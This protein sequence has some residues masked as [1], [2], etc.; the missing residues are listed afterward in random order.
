MILSQLKN[1]TMASNIL[2]TFLI[3]ATLTQLSAQSSFIED[4]KLKWKNVTE[5]TLEFAH[6]MPEDYY[7]YTPTKV[8]M[9]YREQLKHVAGNMLWLCSSFLKGKPTQI[10]PLKTGD[11]K[12]EISAMLARSFAYA[13]ETISALTEKDLNE[14][15]DFIAGTMTR[16]RILFL[17]SD[18]VTHHRGQLVVYLRMKN[19]EP[20]SY[21][22]W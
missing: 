22:G 12:K 14:N 8:E 5:Y 11:S 3:L 19:V 21:R 15:V 4:Y 2:S 13:N 17:L 10:D 7:S 20:P 1:I 6:V 9:T 16:R 18:H